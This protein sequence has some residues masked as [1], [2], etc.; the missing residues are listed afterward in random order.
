MHVRRMCALLLLEGMFCVYL[1][2]I[3]SNL[4]FKA[5]ASL[6]V[7]CLDNLSMDVSGVLKFPIIIVLLYPLPFNSLYWFYILGPPMVDAGILTNVILL[8]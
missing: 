2:S 8:H 5:N 1:K 4:L 3:W 7:F 6:L